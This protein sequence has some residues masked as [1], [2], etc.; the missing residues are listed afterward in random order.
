[1]TAKALVLL[2]VKLSI[3][4]DV[5]A[6]GLAATPAD[7]T[8]LFARPRQLGRAL[9]SMNVIMPAL[10]FVL[11]RGFALNPAVKIALVALAV[12]PVPPFFPRKAVRAQGHEKY[13]VGILVATAALAIVLEPLAMAIFGRLTGTPLHVPTKSVVGLVFLTVL[14]PLFAGIGVRALVPSRAERAAK[15]VGTV[16]LVLLILSVLPMLAR[17][18]HDIPPLIGNGTLLS[19]AIFAFVGFVAGNALGGPD[20]QNRRTLALATTSRHP[21]IAIT[22]AHA[23]YPGQPLTVPAI[24][25]YLL[26]SGVFALAYDRLRGWPRHTATT[27]PAPASATRPRQ[28]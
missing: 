2:V 6:L 28:L 21:A 4:L 11:A 22:L 26:A 13:A 9:L 12:S 24:V 14:L 20:P 19:M 10:A 15:P 27:A 25:L 8:Y 3:A 17:V 1:M 7:A 5:F 23:N 16:A 18:L